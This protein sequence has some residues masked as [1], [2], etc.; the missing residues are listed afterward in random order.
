[1]V[2]SVNFKNIEYLKSGDVV[3]QQA[4]E[5]LTK[6]DILNRLK[7][8]GATLVG[9]IPI[10]IYTAKSDLDIICE[11]QDLKLFYQ[12]VENEF[13]HEKDFK[14][15]KTIV[16]GVPS[17]C[18]QFSVEAFELEVFGQVNAVEDQNAYHHMVIESNIILSEGSEFK[19]QIIQ[20]K[21]SGLNTE[22]AFCK[23]LNLRGDP[24]M[25][26]LDYAEDGK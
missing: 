5:L 2:L 1:M 8:F 21:E 3:Q 26:L 19:K 9:T 18:A 22:A 24:F 12:H 15:S 23:L 25:A 17:V 20:L 13:G 14:I 11:A 6:Y 16:R 4:Y 10:G 7:N